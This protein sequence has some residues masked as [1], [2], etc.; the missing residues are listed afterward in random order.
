MKYTLLILRH[1]QKV[2]SKVPQEFF[3][4]ICEEIRK[5]SDNPYPEGAK[6]LVARS[7]WRIR[8]GEY[9]VIYEIDHHAKT[10]TVLHIGKRKDIYR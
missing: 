2:L 3:E 9:R 5:L 4:N 7:G 6:K 10:V 8:A 1:A